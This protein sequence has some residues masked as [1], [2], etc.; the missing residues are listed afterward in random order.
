MQLAGGGG[1]ALILF[2]LSSFISKTNLS[3]KGLETGIILINNYKKVLFLL[4][5]FC[6]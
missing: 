2:F 4:L 3:V 5:C 1:R 6:F